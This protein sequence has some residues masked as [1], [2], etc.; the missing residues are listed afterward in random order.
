MLVLDD[1]HRLSSPSDARERRLVRGAPARRPSSSCSPPAPTRPSRSARCGRTASC[2]SCAPTSCASP[3]PRRTSSS[4][5]ASGSSLDAGR[6]RAA[7][8]AHRGL[9]RGH[10]P[11]GALAGGPATTSTRWSCAPSTARAR[12]SST[13]SPARCSRRLR[14]RPAGVHAAHLG[15][16][17]ALRAAVRRR[18]S[19]GSDAA[20][21]LD[22][23]RALQPLPAPARR[24]PALV[25]L[26]SPLRPAPAGRARAARAR[27]SC[28]SCTGARSSGTPRS[29]TT[30]EAIHHA[31]RRA[32]PTRRPGS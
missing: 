4:T 32:A 7:R 3:T 28:P 2:S 5:G 22:V 1:F 16:R 23:A 30:D 6:R 31:A 20:A 24:S 25:P 18:R 27:R 9:A 15:A 29:G 11:R 8:R 19:A 10:L 13:S 26:P 12:T 21:T 14:A 17:A